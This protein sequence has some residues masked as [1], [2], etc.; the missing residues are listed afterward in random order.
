[1]PDSHAN[2]LSNTPGS[3]TSGQR[4]VVATM[5][6]QRGGVELLDSIRDKF[7]GSIKNMSAAAASRMIKR[8]TGQDLPYAPGTKRPP[9][10]RPVEGLYPMIT[11]DQ[12]E[13]IE[14]LGL[15]YFGNDRTAFTTWLMSDFKAETPRL[16]MTAKRAGQVIRVLK[17]MIDRRPEVLRTEEKA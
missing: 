16:L 7:G 17:E 2:K 4:Q 3:S 5:A 9:R 8:L 13:Q 6:R 10:R 12:C 1:M 15:K 14:R 11:P